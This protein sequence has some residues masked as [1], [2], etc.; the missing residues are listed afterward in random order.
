[1]VLYAPTTTAAT[2]NPT[3][4]FTTLT[5]TPT[6]TPSPTATPTPTPTLS[7]SPTPTNKP[8]PTLTPSPTPTLTP[9]PTLTADIEEL[10]PELWL[11]ELFR[12]TNIEREKAGVPL[13][14]PA[15]TALLQAAGLR[16]EEIVSLFSHTRPDGSSCF[17]VLADFSVSY[18]AAGENIAKAT[19]GYRSP[20]QVIAMWMGSDGHRKNL[21]STSFSSMGIGYVDENGYEHFVQLFI[22]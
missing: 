16:A 17:T 22:G 19:T 1:M 9:S 18:R 3:N 12:L 13:L 2:T 8:T 4:A 21:L 5:P 11:S 10:T 15:S 14:Q 6:L 7:P 20:A